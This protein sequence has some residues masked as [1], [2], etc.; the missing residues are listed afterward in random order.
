MKSKSILLAVALTANFT[1]IFAGYLFGSS[2]E[3]VN[4]KFLI[5]NRTGLIYEAILD[6]PDISKDEAKKM[7][8]DPI[9][10]ILTSYRDQGFIVIDGAKD[11]QGHY[12]IVALPKESRDI[13]DELKNAITFRK[14]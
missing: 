2:S 13:S 10:A 8:V 14:R 1:G 3:P 11:D 7:I 12:S 5:A 6:N 4:S 9:N